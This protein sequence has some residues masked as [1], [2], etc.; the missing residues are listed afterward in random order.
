M[1]ILSIPPFSDY[2]IGI[3]AAKHQDRK[4]RQKEDTQ[5]T[6]AHT[7]TEMQRQTETDTGKRAHTHTHRPKGARLLGFVLHTQHT[8][9]CVAL[10]SNQFCAL[11]AS[12]TQ[13]LL[14]PPIATCH[15]KFVPIDALGVLKY[16]NRCLEGV[17]NDLD[18]AKHKE[19]DS[20]PVIHNLLVAPMKR[21]HREKR[22]GSNLCFVAADMMIDRHRRSHSAQIYLTHGNSKLWLSQHNEKQLH[23]SRTTRFV[24][25]LH[26]YKFR[27]TDAPY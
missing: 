1:R 9:T 19:V 5:G 17:D 7:N 26:A 20:A 16:S 18:R 21:L 24:R 27:Q 13:R 2:A 6:K 14:M 15:M 23:H 8:Y 22:T 12:T 4:D 11:M 3:Q 10:G 25:C